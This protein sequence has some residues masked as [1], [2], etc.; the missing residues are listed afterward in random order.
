[1]IVVFVR[2]IHCINI[3]ISIHLLAG[4]LNFLQLLLMENGLYWVFAKCMSWPIVFSYVISINGISLSCHRSHILW[5][6]L[7]IENKMKY[8]F[9]CCLLHYARVVFSCMPYC[10]DCS[11]MSLVEDYLHS[12]SLNNIVWHEISL[13]F[14]LQ[15]HPL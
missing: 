5:F 7:K 9:R 11:L 1:M 15:Y 10:G 14:P 12:L 8:C 13:Y 4:A 2:F 6:S 3:F